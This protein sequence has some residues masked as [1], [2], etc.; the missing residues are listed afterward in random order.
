METSSLQQQKAIQIEKSN[1]IAKTYGLLSLGFLLMALGTVVGLQFVPQLLSLG[2]WGF[3][4]VSLVVTI[5]TMVLALMNQKNALG[6]LFFFAF[7]FSIGFFDAPAIAVIFS[8]AV[9]LE[10]FKQA[11]LLTAIITGSLTAYAFITKKDFS[12]LGG[13]LFTGLILVVIMAVVGLFWHNT[14]LS[15][16]MSGIGALVFSGFILYDTSRLIH[17][18]G[19]PIEIAIALFLDIINLFWML[20]NLLNILKGEE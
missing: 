5:G 11:F 17:E 12:F 6:Y 7:T 18:K 9:L 13:F 16:V 3:L 19:T 10:I 20:F 1:L 4:I 15:F 2:K 8:S 14:T